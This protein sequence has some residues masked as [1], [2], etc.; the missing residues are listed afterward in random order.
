MSLLLISALGGFERPLAFHTGEL[1]LQ[2]FGIPV[3][4]GSIAEK[5]WAVYGLGKALLRH[6][7]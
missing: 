3:P 6:P 5:D 2:P 1:S 7:D 4:F